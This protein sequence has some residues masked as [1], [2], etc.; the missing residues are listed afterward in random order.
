M[1]SS[2]R[3]KKP[4]GTMADYPDEV[5]HAAQGAYLHLRDCPMDDA[6]FDCLVNGRPQK[7][8]VSGPREPQPQKRPVGR[9]RKNPVDLKAKNITFRCRHHIWR[10]LESAS[11]E[12]GFSL[13]EEVERRLEASFRDADVAKST[14]KAVVALLRERW[15]N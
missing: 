6:T 9:P 4:K 10:A 12:S 13:S 15:S 8:T 7:I 5:R 1:A 11:S 2:V 3:Q 14:A